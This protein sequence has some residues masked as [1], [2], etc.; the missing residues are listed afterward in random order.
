MATLT[1]L[2]TQMDSVIRAGLRDAILYESLYAQIQTTHTEGYSAGGDLIRRAGVKVD[3]SA[4]IGD[5]TTHEDPRIADMTKAAI[6]GLE[7][8]LAEQADAILEVIVVEYKK[9]SSIATI[10]KMLTSYFD[11]DRV[12][13]TRFARTFTNHVYNQ[14]HLK[15]YEDSGVVDGVRFSAHIDN[16]TSMICVM[17]NGTIWVLGDSDIRAPP[18]HFNCRSGLSP[19]FGK[20]PGGRDFTKEFGSEFVESAT[21]TADTFRSKY[22]GRIAAAG[23]KVTVGRTVDEAYALHG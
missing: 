22:W 21:E 9:G 15:R 7:V 8:L 3:W 20:I 12:A 17:L 10:S 18:L 2:E 16:V 13:A 1:S 5:D 4:P 6:T 23:D 14:A 19:Y 11:D